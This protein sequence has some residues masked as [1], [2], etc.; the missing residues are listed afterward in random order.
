MAQEYG[1]MRV[2]TSGEIDISYR[3]LMKEDIKYRLLENKQ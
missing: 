3:V 2:E 1:G